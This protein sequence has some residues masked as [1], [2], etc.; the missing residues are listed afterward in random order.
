M[1]SLVLLPRYLTFTCS[2][3]LILLNSSS[4]SHSFLFQT[5]IYRNFG[6][7]GAFARFQLV[8]DGPMD[9]QTNWWMGGWTDRLTHLL[10]EMREEEI[11]YEFDFVNA[12]HLY[13]IPNLQRK[14]KI[15]K[16][17]KNQ[18]TRESGGNRTKII[19]I[20]KS[21]EIFFLLV[22]TGLECVTVNQLKFYCFYFICPR[23]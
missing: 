19:E 4:C 18:S 21:Y 8:C 13:R 2:S 1:F 22:H 16:I 10:I 23:I 17:K 5:L 12:P 9:G 7:N 11:Q 6:W 3:V 15:E 14:C 20:S